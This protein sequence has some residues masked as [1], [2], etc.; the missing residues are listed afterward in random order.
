MDILKR[1]FDQELCPE[2]KG[3]NLVISQEGIIKEQK[4]VLEDEIL[5]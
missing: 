1:A 5:V 2:H 4:I 3:K